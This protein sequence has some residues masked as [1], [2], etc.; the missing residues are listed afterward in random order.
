LS[1]SALWTVKYAPQNLKDLCGNK[2][3]V[4]KMQAW[5]EAW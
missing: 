1:K 3:Q 2:G 4:E 5:L